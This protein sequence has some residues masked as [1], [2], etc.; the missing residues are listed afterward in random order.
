MNGWYSIPLLR[1][2]GVPK[3]RGGSGRHTLPVISIYNGLALV[4]AA[5]TSP[6]GYSSSPEEEN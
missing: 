2:G 5:T 6:F 4:D 1:G 3:G